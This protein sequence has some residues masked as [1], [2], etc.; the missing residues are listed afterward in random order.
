MKK[1]TLFL[2]MTALMIT[3]TSGG[4]LTAVYADEIPTEAAETSESTELPIKSLTAKIVD[5]NPYNRNV[6]SQDKFEADGGQGTVTGWLNTVTVENVHPNTTVALRM[7]GI[8][9]ETGSLKLYSYETDGSLKEVPA[10]LWHIQT[11]AGETP[12]TLSDNILYEV[13]FTVQDNE[14][15]D[16]C[17][18][19]KEI[20]ISAVLGNA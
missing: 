8:S 9:G 20:K 11:E 6:L 18:E 5:E 19:E 2:A 1:R 4:S 16:L 13:H 17:E 3:M 7:K 14:A 10:E 15:F 12:D